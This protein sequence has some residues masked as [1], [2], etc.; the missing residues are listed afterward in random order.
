[1]RKQWSYV[2]LALTHRYILLY[3]LCIRNTK[4]HIL[5]AIKR[6]CTPLQ[7]VHAYCASGTISYLIHC[8]IH[9]AWKIFYET[10]Q[11]IGSILRVWRNIIFPITKLIVVMVACLN[12]MR[13]AWNKN[14]RY[15]TALQP[16][17]YHAALSP[18]EDEP[19]NNRE[20]DGLPTSRPPSNIFTMT[21]SNGNISV[22]LALC[23]GNLQVTGEFPAQRSVTRSFDIFFDLNLNKRRS[24][25]SR[26]RWFRTESCSLWRHC[27]LLFDGCNTILIV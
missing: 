9:L 12:Y 10:L 6:T 19:A 20:I 23:A 22:L 5:A 18:W 11:L 24:K 8:L 17:W 2:F 27:K 13:F 1:M 15:Y 3:R 21:S 14:T 4:S 16:T 25:Q 26:H 7:L